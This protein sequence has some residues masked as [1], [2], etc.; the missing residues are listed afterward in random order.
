MGHSHNSNWTCI[1]YRGVMFDGPKGIYVVADEKRRVREPTFIG[2]MAS[3]RRE[4]LALSDELIDLCL[5]ATKA[6]FHR[7]YGRRKTFVDVE[8]LRLDLE[9]HHSV[10]G[11]DIPYRTVWQRVRR[12]QRKGDLSSKD[13]VASLTLDQAA[14]ITAYGGGRR[15]GFTYTGEMFSHLLGTSFSGVTHFLQ[16]IGRYQDRSLVHSRLKK[17]WP[18]DLALSEPALPISVRTGTVYKV[19]CRTTKK[20]YIGL[21]VTSLETRWAQHCRVAHAGTSA[22]PL[23][24]AIRE[25]GAESFDVAAIEV[26][27]PIEGLQ[28]RERYWI[29]IEGCRQPNGFNVSVGGQMGG[30]RRKTVTY[31]GES[32]PSIEE[33]AS[34]L[35]KRTGLKPYVV[36]RRLASGKELPIRARE[37]SRH[38]AAGTNLWRRWKS[39]LRRCEHTDKESVCERW[40]LSFDAFSADVGLDFQEG[41]ELVRTDPSAPWSPANVQWM[42]RAARVVK[43]HGRLFVVDGVE[44]PT[45]RALAKAYGL[46]ASSLRDRIERQRLSPSEAVSRDLGPTSYRKRAESIE[47]DGLPFQSVTAA[48]EY[49][50]VRYGLTFHQARDRLRRGV[51]L[52]APSRSS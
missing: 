52:N 45:I 18:I 51:S 36:I 30:G 22:A 19:V 25:L 35:A 24:Q 32:F 42:S 28:D 21:T 47:V 44:Y 1:Q 11:S 29:D 13:I 46:G 7:R 17:H 38:P 27:I 50:S 37:A 43:T 9:Q 2:R 8:G 14:W 4:G 10:S 12:L 31:G 39:L 6:E 5:Y 49:A 23:H 41:L 15:S 16:E 26:D 20:M 48:A 3:R 40:K 33:A 34:V